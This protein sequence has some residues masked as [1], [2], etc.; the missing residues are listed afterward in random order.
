[1]T[2]IVN[3]QVKDPLKLFTWAIEF[4]LAEEGHDKNQ[5]INK[6]ILRVELRLLTKFLYQYLKE[7]LSVEVAPEEE[8]LKLLQH[9]IQNVFI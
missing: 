9:I 5:F 3:S 4:V 6:N 2:E 7:V 8:E 1:M